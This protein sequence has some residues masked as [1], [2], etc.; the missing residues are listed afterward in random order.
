MSTLASSA[1]V[2]SSVL[3]ST[4][5]SIAR[6]APTLVVRAT[7]F[8]RTLDRPESSASQFV[9][10]VAYTWKLWHADCIVAYEIRCRRRGIGTQPNCDPKRKL[11]IDE[12]HRVREIRSNDNSTCATLGH[13]IAT[14]PALLKLPWFDRVEPAARRIQQKLYS[15]VYAC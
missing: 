1:R 4:S 11:R 12:R 7:L 15:R 5:W 14:I 6:Q 3:S 13:L 9:T 2:L 8:H 10:T